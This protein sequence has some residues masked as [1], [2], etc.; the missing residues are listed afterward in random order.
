VGR[1]NVTKTLMGTSSHWDGGGARHWATWLWDRRFGLTRT[2]L[3]D[4]RISLNGGLTKEILEAAGVILTLSL[5]CVR[6]SG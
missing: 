5:S 4:P 1:G 2:P 3:Q 6:G